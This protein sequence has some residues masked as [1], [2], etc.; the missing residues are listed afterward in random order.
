[1]VASTLDWEGR[2]SSQALP[3]NP[4]SAVRTSQAGEAKCQRWH[5]PPIQ[6]RWQPN[7]LVQ[8]PLKRPAVQLHQNPSR[9]PEK[10]PKLQKP[11]LQNRHPPKFPPNRWKSR[12]R[13]K[14]SV[15]QRKG[16]ARK[17]FLGPVNIF[18]GGSNRNLIDTP[19]SMIKREVNCP[20]D[21]TI[22]YSLSTLY[23]LTLF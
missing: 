11:P 3:T 2:T 1:M 15:K 22:Y 13:K 9:P 23:T 19:C 12:R 4:I 18:G 5:P 10:M 21:P 20:C 7:P 6:S 14:L 16:K 17:A 8:S